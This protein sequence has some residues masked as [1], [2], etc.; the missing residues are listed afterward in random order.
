MIDHRTPAELAQSEQDKKDLREAW[1]YM[2]DQVQLAR[3]AIDDPKYFGPTSTSRNLAEG[4]RYLSGYLHHGVERAFHCDP[5][6]PAFRNGLSTFNKATIENADAIYFYAQIDGRQRYLI[7][8]KAKDFRHWKG[9]E[10]ATDVKK[11]PQYLIFETCD[12]PMSG[13]TGK[14][15]ELVPGFRTGFGRM[16]G[17]DLEIS[18]DGDIELLLAPEKPEGY[19]GNFICTKKGPRRDNPGGDDRYA[20]FVSGRQLFYDWE[21]EETIPLTITPLDNLGGH[22]DPYNP[23]RAIKELRKMGDVVKGQMHF[24]LEFYDKVLNVF[25]NYDHESQYFMPVNAYN[26]PNAASTDTGGGMSTNIYAGGLFDLEEDQALYIEAEFQG[27]PQYTSF[28]LGTPWGESPDYANSQSSLNL[29]QM[30]MTPGSNVQRWVV[31]HK[32]PGVKNWLDTTGLRQGYLSHRWAYSELPPKDSWPTI[33]AKLI[34]L[35]EVQGHFPEDMPILTPEE[36]AKDI[37]AR[38]EHVQKRYRVF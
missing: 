26:Q 35:D 23:E 34:K 29:V 21:N 12:G 31:S 10:R 18:E 3:N 24:W 9:E 25:D 11:A 8:G 13:D 15:S 1:D 17:T 4:Y 20:T 22:P 27:E 2:I 14:M 33:S 5:S 6:F 7:K 28:H 37:A 38:Q 16:D 19:T 32:D 30:Y 36:R